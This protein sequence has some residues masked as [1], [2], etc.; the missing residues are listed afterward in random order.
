MA[1]LSKGDW[2]QTLLQKRQNLAPS[3][4]RNWNDRLCHHVLTTPWFASAQTVLAYWPVRQEP[5]LLP[6]LL[7]HPKRWGL[8]RCLNDQLVFH[9]WQ[10]TDVLQKGHYGIQAPSPQAPQLSA[11]E[12]DLILVP[13]VGCDRAGYRLG[14]GGG[15]YDRL[16]AQ[17]DWQQIPAIG[18]TFEFA[19]IEHFPHDDWDQPLSGICTEAGFF[20][21]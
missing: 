13:A 6:L 10:P 19:V 11:C 8:P 17:P 21:V 1:N 3:Q 7:E 4:W 2:R 20:A 16:R 14:Y 9:T 18:I 5:D 15:Y 12:V